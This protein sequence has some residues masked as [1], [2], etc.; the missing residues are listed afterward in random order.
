MSRLLR[1]GIILI[2]WTTQDSQGRVLSEPTQRSYVTDHDRPPAQ[3]KMMEIPELRHLAK[4]Q[5]TSLPNKVFTVTIA[6]SETCGWLS[7][8]PAKS[9]TCP[10]HQ[11][12]MWVKSIGHIICGKVNE[13]KKWEFHLGC[14]ERDEAL[15]TNICNDTCTGAHVLLCTDISA[16]HCRTYAY[17]DGIQ[18]YR[19]APT[20]ETR[21][22]SV[23]FTYNGQINAE[24][25]TT[26][27]TVSNSRTPSTELV[28]SA[29]S[30]SSPLT[31]P[32]PSSPAH[33][34]PSNDHNIG[35]IIGGAIGGFVALSVV[36]LAIF[37]FV[38][39]SKKDN[40]RS[41]TQVTPMEQAQLTGTAPIDLNAGKMGPDSPVQS[42]WRSS[43][44]TVPSSV[45]NPASPQGWMDQPG[46]PSIQR[47]ASQEAPQTMPQQIPYEMSGD[48][49]QPQAY[50]MIGD[51]TR[52]RVYEMVGDSTRP[53]V[54]ESVA[55]SAHSRI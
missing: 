53:W 15:N 38:R 29:T 51:S 9:I 1:S 12:C 25:I 13:Q 37:W 6:Q 50:E 11:P 42:E 48:S 28:S 54:Y 18:D 4:R 23:F 19:C 2:L 33:Q 20:P 10:N 8:H 41:P 35:P 21:V 31:P 44:M 39:Q 52:P 17:P 55:D 46:S 16:A 5:T 14:Y 22:S 47:A 7:G 45:G 43:T 26:A 32:P 40:T 27:Y 36:A 24:F 34:P 3:T 49:L 30:P